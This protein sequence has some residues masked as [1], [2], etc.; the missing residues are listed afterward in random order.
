MAKNN[1]VFSII[2]ISGA[3]AKCIVDVTKSPGDLLAGE[4]GVFD[5]KTGKAM[6]AAAA[7][8]A[9]E[10]FVAAA[11]DTT[12]DGVADEILTSAGTKVTAKGIQSYELKCYTPTVEQVIDVHSYTA[13][14]DTSYGLKIEFN[15][16]EKYM[17]YGYN[18][19]AKSFM[20][21][22]ECCEG[23]ESCGTGNCAELTKLLIADINADEDGLVTATS[24]ANVGKV[25]VTAV[26]NPV[27]VYSVTLD[28]TVISADLLITDTVISSAQKIADAINASSTF[29]AKADGVGGVFIT[30]KG[31]AFAGTKTVSSSFAVGAGGTSLSVT[32]TT[33]LTT[34]T[35][36]DFTDTA[37]GFKAIYG[38]GCPSLR[39][40]GVTQ[41]INT[42]CNVD[43]K[44]YKQRTPVMVVSKVANTGFSCTGTI[45]TTT[46]PTMRE[47]AGYDL[48]HIEYEVGGFIGKPGVYRTGDLVGVAFAGFNSVI[49]KTTNYHMVD[50]TY[51][52]TSNGGWLDYQNH[53]NTKFVFPC[54]EIDGK[55]GAAFLTVLDAAVLQDTGA[56][57]N[58]FAVIEP[59]ADDCAC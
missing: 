31:A 59:T 43:T 42:Y 34:T 51:D 14:C 4:V 27:G 23:C 47:G 40:T 32:D 30:M 5:Y 15:T 22:T 26:N 46:D 20:V 1:D 37:T 29:S 39:L 25:T 33:Q 57:G 12:G 55:A 10:F 28:A 35:I 18:Q 45:V 52:V 6:N 58:G 44:Y 13:D 50:L 48:A 17:N 54:G 41:A 19:A 21:K 36:T 7:A 3:T 49:S 11:V 16:D 56:T 9:S 38:D 53:F 8:L 24:W 2:P